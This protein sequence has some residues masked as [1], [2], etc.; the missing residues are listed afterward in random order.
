MGYDVSFLKLLGESIEQFSYNFASGQGIAEEP[1]RFGVRDTVFQMKSKETHK[2]DAVVDLEFGLVIAEVI[3]ALKDEYLEHED[4]VIGRPSTR[5][6]GFLAEDLG[7]D[8]PETLPLDN[9]VQTDE[10]VA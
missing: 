2:S 1:D 4:A 5:A 8:G 3:D 6:F 10:G 7:Q 9:I